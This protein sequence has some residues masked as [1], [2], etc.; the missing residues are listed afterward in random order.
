MFKSKEE[1]KE[2]AKITDEYP[3]N[4][5]GGYLDGVDNAFKSITERKEF[6]NRYRNSFYAFRDKEKELYNVFWKICKFKEDKEIVF[7][8][9]K[10]WLFDKCFDGVE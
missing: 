3:G 7:E 4:Y 9:F 5:Y 1:L 10:D 8:Q 2:D 6:Y